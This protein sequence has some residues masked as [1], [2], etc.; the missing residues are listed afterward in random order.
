MLDV[1]N[2]HNSL[3]LRSG[4]DDSVVTDP[5]PMLGVQPAFEP[6]HLWP[7]E[8][9]MLERLNAGSDGRFDGGIEFFVLPHR[10]G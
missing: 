1:V 9:G 10:V 7:C 3:R 6:L 2:V 8:G 4:I 5:I